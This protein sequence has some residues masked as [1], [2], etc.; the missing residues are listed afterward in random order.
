MWPFNKKV[1]KHHTKAE[2]IDLIQNSKYAAQLVS[3]QMRLEEDDYLLSGD[4]TDILYGEVSILVKEPSPDFYRFVATDVEILGRGKSVTHSIDELQKYADNTMVRDSNRKG[5]KQISAQMARLKEKMDAASDKAEFLALH[6]ELEMLQSD[7]NRADKLADA[8][9]DAA[10]VAYRGLRAKDDLAD[11]RVSVDLTKV[12]GDSS[13]YQVNKDAVN[14]G[15]KDISEAKKDFDTT[16]KDDGLTSDRE[17]AW[18][19]HQRQALASKEEE[20]SST[21]AKKPVDDDK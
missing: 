2:I 8:S 5:E 4:K 18:E 19:E 3:L 16:D 11:I 12:A 15:V 10:D 13:V 1:E 7:L 21:L 9:A 17:K 6:D 14:S 20:S